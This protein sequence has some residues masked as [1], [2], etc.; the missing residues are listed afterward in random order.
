VWRVVAFLALALATLGLYG[1]AQLNVAGR[2]KEF[3]I[4]K[5]LG[6]S[7]SC[8]IFSAS[9]N[10]CGYLLHTCALGLKECSDKFPCPIHHEIKYYKDHLPKVMRKTTV[11]ELVDDLVKGKTFLNKVQEKRTSR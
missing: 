8:I 3:S 7:N 6:A 4:R 5:V 2:T 1:L 9:M 10:P 11:K